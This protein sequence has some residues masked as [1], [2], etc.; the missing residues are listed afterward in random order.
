MAFGIIKDDPRRVPVAQAKVEFVKFW[1]DLCEKYSLT[2]PEA[3][4][5]LSDQIS[6][7]ANAAIREER[8]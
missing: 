1:A 5:L 6:W 2:S 8:R 3:V 4:S 7:E